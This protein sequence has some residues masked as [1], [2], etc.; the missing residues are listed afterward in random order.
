MKQ[1]KAIKKMQVD[2]ITTLNEL[3]F[4]NYDKVIFL[5]EKSE[6]KKKI[7][8]IINNENKNILCIIGPEGGFT[9]NEAQFL[10]NKG[11]VEITLGKRILRAETA[12]ILVASVISHNYTY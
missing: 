9:E 10:K 6:N 11:A 3:N 4:E 12:C 7:T 2:R 8:D 1:C 5:Y